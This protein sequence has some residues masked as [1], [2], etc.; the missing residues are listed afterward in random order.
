MIEHRSFPFHI[1]QKRCVSRNFI[2]QNV[3]GYYDVKCV[4]TGEN[5]G[6]RTCPVWNPMLHR[7]LNPPTPNPWPAPPNRVDPAPVSPR[8][9]PN[10]PQPP[11]P[12][13]LR[14]IQRVTA[15]LPVPPEFST[16]VPFMDGVDPSGTPQGPEETFDTRSLRDVN[17]SLKEQSEHD[18]GRFGRR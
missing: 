5:C 7:S 15:A 13:P 18:C 6:P 12:R 4:E 11:A 8:E 3:P 10:I 14:T 9:E 17:L 16:V 2:Y 1:I